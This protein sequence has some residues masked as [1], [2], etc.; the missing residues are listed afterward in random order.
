M[1]FS[2]PNLPNNSDLLARISNFLPKIEA[3]NEELEKTR[4]E[5]IPIDCGLVLD[6][7][8]D[9]NDNDDA[10]EDESSEPTIQLKV[11]IGEVDKNKEIFDL[12]GP[13]SSEACSNEDTE[14]DAARDGEPISGK[15]KALA[16]L[17]KGDEKPAKKS[18]V[19]IQEMS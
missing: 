2:S 1:D 17:L 6:D 8:D 10:D 13:T 15:E 19:L 3:A 11:Q 18:K 14:D 7:D 4:D 5:N 9:D 16:E 12:L